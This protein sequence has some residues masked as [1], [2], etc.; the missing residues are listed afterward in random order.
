MR[1]SIVRTC[2]VIILLHQD[3]GGAC[4]RMLCQMAG[5]TSPCRA[6][7][8]WRPAAAPAK[9]VHLFN[10]IFFFDIFNDTAAF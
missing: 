2:S 5:T 4:A 9:Q 7:S 6:G 8:P 3:L 10:P 1:K